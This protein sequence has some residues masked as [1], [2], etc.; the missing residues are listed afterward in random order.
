METVIGE[1]MSHNPKGKVYFPLCPSQKFCW[2]HDCSLERVESRSYL[3]ETYGNPQHDC[4]W[5]EGD[6]K[7]EALKSAIVLRKAYL[8]LKVGT[9]D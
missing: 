2:C 7:S 6:Y 3:K 5:D 9:S 4:Y 1:A 8:L